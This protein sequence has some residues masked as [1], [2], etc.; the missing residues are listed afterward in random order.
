MSPA[1]VHYYERV[2][3]LTESESVRGRLKAI[4]PEEMQVF[5]LYQNQL[6]PE[7]EISSTFEAGND[8]DL[9]RAVAKANNYVLSNRV[10]SIANRIRDKVIDEKAEVDIAELAALRTLDLTS[11]MCK[12]TRKRL[13]EIIKHRETKKEADVLREA[14]GTKSLCFVCESRKVNMAFLDPTRKHK[15]VALMFCGQCVNHKWNLCEKLVPSG[16]KQA[17]MIPTSYRGVNL[18]VAK[19]KSII[20]EKVQTIH[21]SGDEDESDND[22]SSDREDK[23]IN[24]MFKMPEKP[25]VTAKA[26]RDMKKKHKLFVKATKQAKHIEKVRSV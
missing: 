10:C 22:S 6:V 16:V 17:D 18:S 3:K 13:S 26:K 12:G 9:D 14:L 8:D 21:S 25:V 4:T 7:E 1:A 5:L 15:T 19:T 20:E 23:I 11:H 2:K 24:D